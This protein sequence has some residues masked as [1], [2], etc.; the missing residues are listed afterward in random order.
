MAVMLAFLCFILSSNTSS[1]AAAAAA[2][3]AAGNGLLL[4]KTLLSLVI[5]IP[6]FL[7]AT[8]ICLYVTNF[9]LDLRVSGESC[10]AGGR[11]YWKGGGGSRGCNPRSGVLPKRL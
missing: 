5:L 11:G 4:G 10:G 6:W 7:V 8:L 9:I 2:A 3:A 1:D